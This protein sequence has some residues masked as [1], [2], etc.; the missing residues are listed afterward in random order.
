MAR[1]FSL[2]TVL[3]A[4]PHCWAIS[5]GVSPWRVA[6]IRAAS[7][8]LSVAEDRLLERGL[9]VGLRG[10]RPVERG[11]VDPVERLEAPLALGPLLDRVDGPEEVGPLG[12]LAAQDVAD[13]R[14]A[15]VAEELV[16]P[17]AAQPLEQVV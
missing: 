16:E 1:V 15:D 8:G 17:V 3:G 6:W 9:P 2:L 11:G 5:A 10:P 12:G 4:M 7:R 14:L 13:A